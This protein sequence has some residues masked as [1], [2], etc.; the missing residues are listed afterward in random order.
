MEIALAGHTTQINAK[1]LTQAGNSA[2]PLIADHIPTV[3]FGEMGEVLKVGAYQNR[4]LQERFAILAMF[5]NCK[6]YE[7]M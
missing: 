3:Y 7:S 1:P 6:S 4:S 2:A 5:E